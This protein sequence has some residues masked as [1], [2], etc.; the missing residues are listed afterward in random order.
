MALLTLLTDFGTRD[1][2]VAAVKGV[3]LARAPGVQIVDLGHEIA[4]G[5]LEE[6]AF[7]LKSATPNYPSGTVHLAVVDPGVGS[8]RRML[9]LATAA[10]LFLA[11]DNGLLTPFLDSAQGLWAIDR[12]DLYLPAPGAT[13]HGRDRFAPVA[14]WLLAGGDPAE[15]GPAIEDPV[16]LDLPPPRREPSRL[17]GRVAHVDRF[18]NLITDLPFEWLGGGFVEARIGEHSTR[19]L[20]RNYAAIPEGEAAVL[21]GSLGTV[22]L[23]MDRVSLA[24]QWG[25]GRGGRVEVVTRPGY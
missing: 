24:E 16:R 22:E 19:W 7:F 11:P 1:P 25:V 13:F 17:I 18:G 3:V 23:A 6:A 15:L 14:A 5:D 4:P 20:V 21:A 8:E 2:F 12:P 9:A 10:A